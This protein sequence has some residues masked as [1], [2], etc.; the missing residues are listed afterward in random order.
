LAKKITQVRFK[1]GSRRRVGTIERVSDVSQKEE[2]QDKQRKECKSFPQTG[3]PEIGASLTF[4]SCPPHLLYTGCW[5]PRKMLSE[6]VIPTNK[7][8]EAESSATNIKVN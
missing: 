3:I 6:Y 8:S 7:W 5:L 1:V 2:R 4:Q